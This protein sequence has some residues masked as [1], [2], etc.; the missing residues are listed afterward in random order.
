V[1]FIVVGVGV[2]VLHGERDFPEELRSIATSIALES[3]ADVNRVDVASRVLGA[4]DARYRQLSKEGFVGIRSEIL[5]L[6][7]LMGN[8]TRVKTGDE[9][10]EG[11]AVDI[12]ETGALI[13]RKENGINQRVLAGDATLI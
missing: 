9:V 2:N 13:L 11:V 10:V 6:S 7:S 12:D 5:T 3:A 4:V 8:L 1:D